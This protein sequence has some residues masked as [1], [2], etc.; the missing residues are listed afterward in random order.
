MNSLRVTSE[1]SASAVMAPPVRKGFTR[2]MCF[3]VFVLIDSVILQCRWTWPT[4]L[5]LSDPTKLVQGAPKWWLLS[6]TVHV[7]AACPD[8]S[9]CLWT[10]V[11]AGTHPY[12]MQVA[13][14]IAWSSTRAGA[15]F[16]ASTLE[17]ACSPLHNLHPVLSFE[18]PSMSDSRNFSTFSDRDFVAASVD[19]FDALACSTPTTNSSALPDHDVATSVDTFDVLAC[20]TPT[21]DRSAPS[22]LAIA[23]SYG[24]QAEPNFASTCCALSNL[25]ILTHILLYLI[26]PDQLKYRSVSHHWCTVLTQ[27]THHVVYFRLPG[28]WQWGVVD[29][30]VVA[31]WV[32]LYELAFLLFVSRWK[33]AHSIRTIVQINWIYRSTCF[34]RHVL[35]NVDRLEIRSEACSPVN[36]PHLPYPFMVPSL[37]NVLCLDGCS[38]RAHSLEGL[39]SPG[40]RLVELTLSNVYHGFMVGFF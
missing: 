40:M 28:D 3:I 21:N 4:S 26:L 36:V 10:T 32:A 7:N 37:V 35:R 30:E 29:H 11:H 22:D 20:S 6:S 13:A 27:Y 5:P 15:D 1:S 17:M 14:A 19:T 24:T 2:L 33:A 23:V 25:S 16:Y 31:L 38:L 18:L 34:F 12:Y 9:F 8:P 39:M